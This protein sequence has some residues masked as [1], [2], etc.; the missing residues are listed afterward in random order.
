MG[1][2]GYDVSLA[3]RHSEEHARKSRGTDAPAAMCLNDFLGS[4]CTVAVGSDW[5][6]AGWGGI[7]EEEAVEEEAI[8]TGG[9][10]RERR[11]EEGGAEAVRRRRA[12]SWVTEK[13]GQL[14]V[15]CPRVLPQ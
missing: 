12:A 6:A 3:I 13:T 8:G 11:K 10:R 9:T 7:R 1:R 14:R 15:P 4:H 2:V 5:I